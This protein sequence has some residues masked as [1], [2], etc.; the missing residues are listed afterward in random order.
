MVETIFTK[1]VDSA[2]TDGP[3]FMP[4]CFKV[5]RNVKFLELDHLKQNS[6]I[7]MYVV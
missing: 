5:D 1:A 7:I 6:F 3:V 2:K 4:L